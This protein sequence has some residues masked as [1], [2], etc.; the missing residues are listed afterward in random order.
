VGEFSSAC[1]P[2]LTAHKPLG[3][4]AEATTE[5]L[6]GG[7]SYALY[8]PFGENRPD[9]FWRGR[10]TPEAARIPSDIDEGSRSTI[11]FRGY[12]VRGQ[13]SSLL[14]ARHRSQRHAGS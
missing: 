3:A 6:A 11:D 2:H 1:D 8:W 9:G 10:E 5:A 12:A 7:V 13:N 4:P 14:S